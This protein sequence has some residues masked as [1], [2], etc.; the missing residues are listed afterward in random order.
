MNT[1]EKIFA[2]VLL[3]LALCGCSHNAAPPAAPIST[4]MENAPLSV[5]SPPPLPPRVMVSPTVQ[6]TPSVLDPPKTSIVY[7]PG[8][9]VPPGA[10]A[11]MV[12]QPDGRSPDINR[13]YVPAQ[14]ELTSGT[15][16]TDSVGLPPPLSADQ[17]VAEA[18]LSPDQKFAL[19]KPRFVQT[20]RWQERQIALGKPASIPY[21]IDGAGN[22]SHIE[23]GGI[24]RPVSDHELEY[25]SAAIQ[26][27]GQQAM[28]NAQTR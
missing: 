16:I 20:L 9:N 26:Q 27:E 3:A 10:P 24:L 18:K 7:P 6:Y 2:A 8:S 11:A 23:Q 1:S 17:M 5:S 21:R 22:I 25:P 13:G 19:E 14:T 15:G 28:R 4:V 12:P